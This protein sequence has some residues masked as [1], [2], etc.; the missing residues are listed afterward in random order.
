MMLKKI[1]GEP[2]NI[3][4]TIGMEQLYPII[5]MELRFSQTINLPKLKQAIKLVTQVIPQLK[6]TYNLNDNSWEVMIS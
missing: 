3:L 1:A 5:R 4:H 6:S 2:L